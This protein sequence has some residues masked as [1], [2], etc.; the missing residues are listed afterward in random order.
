V[1][2][3]RA[4]LAAEAALVPEPTFDPGVDRAI[5]AMCER[6]TPLLGGSTAGLRARV[7]AQ[8]AV[9]CDHLSDLDEAYPAVEEALALAAESDDA[10]ALEAA[11]TAHHMV[12]SGPDGLAE[13]EDNAERM[14]ALGTRTGRA[15]CCLTAAEWRFD[16]AAEHGDLSRAARELEEIARWAER[17][18]GPLSRWRL[19]R[20]RAMLAQA[21]GQLSDAYRYG[22][23]ALAS[24]APTGFPPAFMLWGGFLAT[25]GHHTGQT[26]ESLAANG[27]TEADAGEQDWPLEGI[28][29]TLGPAAQLA[30]A[31]RL[32]EASVLYRRLGPASDWQ[33]SPHA[34]LFTW[35]MGITTALA[36]GADQEVAVLRAKLGAYRGHHIVNGRYAMA[37][38]GPAELW[39]G[40]GAAHLGLF[41][42]ASADL[43]QAAK[44]CAANGAEG[45]RA[46]AE[47]ELAGALLRRSGPDDLTRARSLLVQARTRMQHIGMPSLQA[48]A[49]ALLSSIDADQPHPLTRREREVAELVGQGLTNRQIAARLHLSERTAQNHVQHILDKLDLPNRSQIAVWAARTR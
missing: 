1:R 44:L 14:W 19:L 4:D 43:E 2:L 7:L 34:A 16:A 23:Q 28:V 21:R 49:E 47:Y 36:V 13:R 18:G 31:G 45:F 20:C 22:A 5:R 41:E 29:L 32:R 8:Y 37:Y 6:V 9:V 27:I 26:A 24:V 10:G 15:A 3:D 48:K 11:V 35:T 39:L 38:Y 42:E 17:V 33:E 12:R 46:E 25:L 40:I 30:E